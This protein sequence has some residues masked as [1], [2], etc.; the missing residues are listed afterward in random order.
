MSVPESGLAAAVAELTAELAAMR[1][2]R[3]RRRLV[4][5][6][7]GVLVSQLRIPPAEAG[8]H[9]TRLA[10]S[11]GL[12]VPDMA[13]DIV[14]GAAGAP[15]AAPGVPATST[16]PP[17]AEARRMRRG[18][19]AV[20]SNDTAADAAASLLEGSLRA[21]GVRAVFLWRRTGTD[22]LELAG[23]AGAGPQEAEHW[24]WVPPEGEG[25]LHR[26]LRSV[27]PVWLPAG[28]PPERGE[29]LPGP[30]PEAAR[31]LVPLVRDGA[32]TGLALAV[33]PGP[34]ELTE[35]IRRTV[36]ALCAPTAYVLDAEA[37]VSAVPP[38]VT[39]L[40]DVLD[41]PGAVLGA[42][43]AVAHLN[44]AALRALGGASRVGR[45]AAQVFPHTHAE[46][47]ALAG[48]AAATTAPQVADRLPA[49][50]E[51]RPL[52]RDVRVVPL[53]QGRAVALWRTSEDRGPLLTRAL[54]RL[55]RL[56]SFEDDLAGGGSRWSEHAYAVFGL[57]PGDPPVPLRSLAPL[58]HP[59]DVPELQELLTTLAESHEGGQALVRV[60][61]GDGGVR[62]VRIAAEPVL[63]GGAATG[64]VGV[65]QDVSAQHHTEVA[66]NATFDQLSAVQRDAVLR[67]RLVLRL[68]HAIVPEAP[69]LETVPG[70][71]VAARYRPAV[72]EDRVGGDWYDVQTLPG[73]KALVTVG[74]IA[75]HGIASA[76][77]MIALRGA[78]R[79]LAFA[80]RAPGRLMAWLNEVTLHTSSQP[81]ATALAALFD[82]ADHSLRW[83]S[84]GHPPPLLLRNGR[85]R[86]L[87]GPHNVL[88][89]ALPGAAYEEATVQL[90]PG[91]TL[92]LY[93]DGFVER[94]HTG[95]DESLE[96]FRRAAE[97]LGPG[98]PDE[99]ADRLM[100]GVIGDTDDDTSLVVVRVA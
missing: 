62:H 1:S 31:A 25:P 96:A 93:T 72:E 23:Q 24:H 86:F 71:Q 49:D 16:G 56:A 97:L 15:S 17:P 2:D 76:T 12:G 59:E 54:G 18:V 20:L 9:L 50:G 100:T 44:P 5:L 47:L 14:N 40:L 75:G 55:E 58:L 26:A 37:P 8:D 21:L 65:F 22:C 36:P 35:E 92:L 68:Q 46:L 88:L 84:A 73:G 87:T 48:R 53:G 77:S 60:V 83:T 91:D 78:L 27:A 3:A 43:G 19:A 98:P 70:L 34:A 81:T 11:T 38:L 51:R 45:P 90:R 69:T 10:A 99:Q 82:R 79:G 32:V 80:E 64:V 52:M 57:R 66:L 95:L 4:D 41:R 89:G 6:A 61:R 33:W 30:A 63:G 85:A 42:D 29:R 13:A 28:T 7:T 74:D 67:N 39:A 94:R